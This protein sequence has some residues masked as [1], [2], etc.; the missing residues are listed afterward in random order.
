MELDVY[1]PCSQ[2]PATGP[3]PKPEESILQ[4]YVLILND[5]LKYYPSIYAYIFR[6]SRPF[7]FP[8]KISYAFLI[9]V[10]RSICRIILLDF[11]TLIYHE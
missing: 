10:M 4:P 8:T 6:V 9:T 11:I 1:L 2:V 5:L 7:G 3:Y